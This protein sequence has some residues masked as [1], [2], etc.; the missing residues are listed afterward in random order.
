MSQEATKVLKVQLEASQEV[1]QSL[2]GQSRICNWLYNHL[3]EKANKIKLTFIQ[4][5]DT[6]LAK[7]LYTERGL[8]DLLPS[9]KKEF[10][11]LKS[12]HSSP[13]KN[14]ALRLSQTIQAHQKSKKG[15][16]RGKQSRLATISLLAS[17]LVFF[18]I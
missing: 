12:V 18:V 8:R 7:T 14:A 17:K 9:L 16:R 1:F 11:F 10:P 3:L 5:Q 15:K 4:T 6:A 13:L 2:D